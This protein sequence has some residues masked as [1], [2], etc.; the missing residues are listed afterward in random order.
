[1]SL[2][3]CASVIQLDQ[4]HSVAMTPSEKF[5]VLPSLR[6]RFGKVKRSMGLS[7]ATPAQLQ[8]WRKALRVKLKALTGYDTLARCPLK[9]RITEEIDRGDYVRQRVEIQTEPGVFMPL[10]VLIPKSA[11]GRTAA[12]INPHGHGGGGKIAVA[13]DRDHPAVA[14]AIETYNYAYGEQFVRAGLICFCPDARGFGERQ[15]RSARHDPLEPSCAAINHMALPLGR[16]VT[17]MWVWD[18]HRLVDYIQTRKD[19]DGGRIGCAG[20]SG[21]GLQTLWATALDDRIRAAVVSGYFYGYRQALLERYT[22][23]SCNYV[24]HLF[25]TIDMGDLAALVAPRPLLIETGTQDPLNGADGV[26]NVRPQVRIAARAY[27]LLDA[28]KNLQHDVF[29]GG[30]RW[31]GIRSVPWLVR[32]LN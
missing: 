5:S 6:R 14:Q 26:K 17:G 22:N 32:Q 30:H 18:L 24:P 31:H 21:G 4:E 12:V 29:E 7:A 19:C 3:L 9:P 8:R 11:H 27:R 10:F 15:E 16:T 2:C 1:M 23:C 28:G 20:L 25:E 13:G